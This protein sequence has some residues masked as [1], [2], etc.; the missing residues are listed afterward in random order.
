MKPRL[1]PPGTMR[2]KPRRDGPLSNFTFNFNFRRYKWGF[3]AALSRHAVL[4]R[5]EAFGR[6]TQPSVTA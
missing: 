1:K 3:P 5:A 4:G 2:L 6:M